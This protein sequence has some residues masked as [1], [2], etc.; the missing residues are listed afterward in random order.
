MFY[1]LIKQSSRQLVSQIILGPRTVLC[2]D[3]K[4]LPSQVSESLNIDPQIST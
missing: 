4:F 1:G 3:V 2:V